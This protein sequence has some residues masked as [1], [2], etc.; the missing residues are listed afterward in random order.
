MSGLEFN[1]ILGDGDIVLPEV[2]VITG[3]FG[4]VRVSGGVPGPPGA[5]EMALSMPI[6]LYVAQGVQPLPITYDM[7][8]RRVMAAVSINFP[9]LGSDLIFDILKNGISIFTLISRPTILDGDTV[10]I[11]VIPNDNLI[12]AGDVL[13]VDIIQVGSTQP[14]SY[15]TLVLEVVQTKE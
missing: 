6:E 11:P 1:V 3:T 9:P 7:Y 4:T 13:T 10:S 15:A 14:G 12:L 8:I 2:R 5:S